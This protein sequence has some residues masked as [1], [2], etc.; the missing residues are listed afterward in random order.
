MG[1]NSPTDG[2]SPDGRRIEGLQALLRL[3]NFGA[4]WRQRLPAS[5]FPAIGKVR[6]W[7][8]NTVRRNSHP[9]P[10]SPRTAWVPAALSLLAVFLLWAAVTSAQLIPD[11]LLPAPRAVGHRL[12]TALLGLGAHPP[13]LLTAL[14]N[15]L[16][17]ALTGCA[18][19]ALLGVP[20]GIALARWRLLNSALQPFLAASQAVPAV[21]L[22]PLLVVWIG[23]GMPSIVVL[24]TIM[25]IFP[26]IVSTS[27]GVH[28]IDRDVIAAARLDGAA[29]LTLLFPIIVPLA[30]PS[31]LAGLRTGFTLSITGAV[32]GEMIIGG[33]GL[34]TELSRAQ[35]TG[36]I[37]GM[38][39]VIVVMAAAAISIYLLIFTVEKHVTA[40]VR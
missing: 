9:R 23:Y 30:A 11:H 22:A 8:V 17:A 28:A 6:N 19:A 37:T 13:Y 32:V 35:P 33:A 3:R 4:P 24:C 15:T 7:N 1:W 40:A 5:K 16:A 14:G 38:F 39:A 27:V 34:G 12:A 10:R 18:W 20:L 21:A 29:R 2:N 25:V 26:I 36:D 31:I